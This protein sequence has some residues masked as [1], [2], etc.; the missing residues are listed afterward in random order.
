MSDIV[1][2]ANRVRG[3]FKPV[4]EQAEL[5][6]AM[7][8]S[9]WRIMDGVSYHQ[10]IPLPRRVAQAGAIAVRDYLMEAM[11]DWA[12][13]N[14]GDPFNTD[15]QY[16][17]TSTAD[18]LQ[19]WDYDTRVDVLEQTHLAAERNP[20]AKAAVNYT[21]LFAVGNGADISYLNEDVETVCQAFLENPDNNWEE[22]EGQMLEAL[23][24]DGDLFPRF[25]TGAEADGETP[26]EVVVTLLK[27]WGVYRIYH[28]PGFFR[29]PTEYVYRVSESNGQDGNMFVSETIPADQVQH[30]AINRLPYEQRGRP[31]LFAVLP[32]LKAY[33][34][35]LEDKARDMHFSSILYD[36]SLANA[37][38]AQVA[39]R[40]A[41]IAQPPAGPT[42]TVHNDKE[43]WT[44]T[45]S[46]RTGGEDDEWARKYKIES[47]TGLGLPEYMLG[48]GQNANLASATAQQLPA[49]KTFEDWQAIMGRVVRGILKYVVQVNVDAGVLSEEVP[50]VDGNGDATGDTIKAVAAFDVQYQ[51]IE[52]T[53]PLNVMQAIQIADGLDLM[54][55]ETAMTK[56]PFNVDPVVEQ[57]KIDN[58]READLDKMRQGVIPMPPGFGMNE[59]GGNGVDPEPE[60]AIA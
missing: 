19:E 45:D 35:A 25:H 36:V 7:V 16:R 41:Q 50:E 28:E 2:F 1:E 47:A 32:W 33:K 6:G 48:D 5:A 29:R 30:Y 3:W 26:G 60:P 11:P 39:A 34:Q 55:K 59:P 15:R 8:S 42:V 51:K 23:Y 54:S 40:A 27:P 44:K 58:E 14:F 31:D 17:M 46:V 20:T 22:L 52:S 56:T 37:T 38:S 21:R 53:D 4:Q 9:S 18:P 24:I 12:K 49:I 10:P 43:T 57:Q 13:S